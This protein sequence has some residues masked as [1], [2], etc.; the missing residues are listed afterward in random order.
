M[1]KILSI[2]TSLLFLTACQKEVPS[3]RGNEYILTETP[4]N[5]EITLAF[6]PNENRFFGKA[7]NR[8]FGTYQIDGNQLI[9]GAVGSTMMMGPEKAM[10]AEQQYFQDLAR[11]KTF[12]VTEDTLTITLSND[13]K[14]IFQK[15]E[16][17]IE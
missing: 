17:S 1:K 16:N 13:K 15:K 2:L 8:Y 9:L 11:V 12:Q 5:V 4:E 3:I 6:A 7:V 10:D 14:L